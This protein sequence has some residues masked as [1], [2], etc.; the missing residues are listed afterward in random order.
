MIEESYS[1]NEEIS[2]I[3]KRFI[4]ILIAY[5]KILYQN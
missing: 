3:W 4:I 2:K 1:N 5:V